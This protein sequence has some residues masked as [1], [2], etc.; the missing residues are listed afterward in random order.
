MLTLLLTL[1]S[2][3][4]GVP[5]P[6]VDGDQAISCADG[7]SLVQIMGVTRPTGL[8][9]QTLQKLI[10]QELIDLGQPLWAVS[11]KRQNGLRAL[12]FTMAPGV[13][14]ATVAESLPDNATYTIDGQKLA[15]TW[16]I[17]T[18]TPAGTLAVIRS[19]EASNGCVMALANEPDQTGGIWISEGGQRTEARLP[20]KV[21]KKVMTRMGVPMTAHARA[22]IPLDASTSEP[23]VVA[24]RINMD[25]STLQ[26]N[27]WLELAKI[28]KTLELDLPMVPGAQIGLLGTPANAGLVGSVR[29]QSKKHAKQLYKE[30]VDESAQPSQKPL[31]AAIDGPTV[32]LATSQALLS[33][34]ES[35]GQGTPWFPKGSEGSIPPQSDPGVFVRLSEGEKRMAFAIM[36]NESGQFLLIA[37]GPKAA[38][39][40][41]WL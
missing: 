33:D 18:P 36:T 17:P 16:E 35:P 4:A 13:D 37:E 28:P 21:L 23:V 34:I 7:D 41:R 6:A 3:H 32:F 5:I 31:F 26:L 29:L 9:G 2:A 38:E 11:S 15:F 8:A 40:M 24:M 1:A 12:S 20:T 10:L 22:T 39:V 30:L 27:Q 14:P 19:F 25:L